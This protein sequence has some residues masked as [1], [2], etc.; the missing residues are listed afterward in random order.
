MTV[1]TNLAMVDCACVNNSWDLREA[2][3]TGTSFDLPTRAQSYLFFLA[4]WVE[5]H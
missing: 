3:L 5:Q 1:D 2:T 4:M